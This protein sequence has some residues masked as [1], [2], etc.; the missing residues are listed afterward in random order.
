LALR[1]RWTVR[2]CALAAIQEETCGRAVDVQAPAR[3]ETGEPAILKGVAEICSG[4]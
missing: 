2:W 3:G 4:S 1:A